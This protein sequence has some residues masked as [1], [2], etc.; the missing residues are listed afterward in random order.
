[1]AGV[2][3]R[4]S[5][6][7]GCACARPCSLLNSTRGPLQFTR[8]LPRAPRDL[9]QN[10]RS[11]RRA[12]RAASRTPALTG[13]HG[14]PRSRTDALSP[15]HRALAATHARSPADPASPCPSPQ[16]PSRDPSPPRR[17]HSL[18]PRPRTRPAP[19]GVAIRPRPRAPT[20]GPCPPPR[21]SYGSAPEPSVSL[22]RSRLSSQRIL[23]SGARAQP[24]RRTPSRSTD[25]LLLP[26]L[27]AALLRG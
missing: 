11:L 19:G 3:W 22:T 25:D 21:W 14:A 16:V 12:R 20:S 17:D 2:V 9:D 15:G 4:S 5:V 1:M 18:P 27:R 6:D 10:R 7:G 24:H 23:A 8:A 26:P 13:W